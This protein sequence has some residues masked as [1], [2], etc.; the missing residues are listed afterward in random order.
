MR[1]TKLQTRMQQR[2]PIGLVLHIGEMTTSSGGKAHPKSL[3]YF[4]AEG[5]FKERFIKLCGSRP[6]RLTILFPKADPVDICQVFLEGRN[7]SGVLMGRVL[8]HWWDGNQE[9]FE[10]YSPK[11]QQWL[12]VSEE[13][14]DVLRRGGS[15]QDCPEWQRES[16]ELADKI[17]KTNDFV[18]VPRKHGVNSFPIMEGFCQQLSDKTLS[19]SLLALI[20]GKGAYARFKE[21]LQKHD[22]ADQWYDFREQKIRDIAIAWCSDNNIKYQ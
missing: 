19:E 3:D 6:K 2:R 22:L 4:R 11:Q 17:L 20:Q 21:A 15:I 1:F 5:H 10:I 16:V 12:V 14:F 8:S 9:T 18:K 7:G 13:D